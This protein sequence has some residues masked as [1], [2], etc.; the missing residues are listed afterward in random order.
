MA[1][2]GRAVLGCGSAVVVLFLHASHVAR[3][4]EMAGNA[5]CRGAIVVHSFR[6]L[7]PCRRCSGMAG[8]A[9][10]GAGNG[11]RDV[12]ADAGFG[13]GAERDALARVGA[14]MA[15]VAAVGDRTVNH[16]GSRET[17]G[18]RVAYAMAG[19]A[20]VYAE[21]DSRDRDMAGRHAFC[22]R[23][24][25]AG[26]ALVQGCRERDRVAAGCAGKGDETAVAG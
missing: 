12:V 22:G 14:V 15:R 2:G 3:S 18:G 11:G 20:G 10:Q 26:A 9:I 4:R 5:A 17:G 8:A 16:G 6:R 1:R 24:V 19:I 7:R 25:V 23:S 13:L 21:S